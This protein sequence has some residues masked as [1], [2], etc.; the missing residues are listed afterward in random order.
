MLKEMEKD[1]K[2][3]VKEVKSQINNTQIEIFQNANMS[4]LNLSMNWRLN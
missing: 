3:I 2:T 1:F 4:L